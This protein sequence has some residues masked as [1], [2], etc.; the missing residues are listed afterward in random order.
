MKKTKKKKKASTRAIFHVTTVNFN[1][2]ASAHVSRN[3]E[4]LI[5][6]FSERGVVFLKH[7]FFP[8]RVSYPQNVSKLHA[9][10]VG[11]FH[12]NDRSTGFFSLHGRVMNESPI[13]HE[14]SSLWKRLPSSYVSDYVPFN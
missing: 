6:L 5:E 7:I 9:L 4:K 12:S 14:Y 8:L 13:S 2:H 10:V 11:V 1:H 3:R